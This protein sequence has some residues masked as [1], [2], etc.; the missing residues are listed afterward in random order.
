M[1]CRLS[2]AVFLAVTLATG[3]G[4]ALTL[5]QNPFAAPLV[6]RSLSEARVALERAM[7]RQVTPDWLVPRLDA[8]LAEDDRDRVAMLSALASQHGVPLPPATWAAIDAALA[9]AS[10]GER[11]A[12]CAACMVDITSCQGAGHIAACAL[13]FEMTVAG[14]VN[15][16][17]RQAQAAIAGDDVDRIETGLALV[18]V[19]ATLVAVVSGGSSYVVKAGATMLRLARRMGAITPAFGRV[20]ADAA[21][22][23]VDWAALARA[24]PLA[25]ITDTAKL[26]RLGRIAEDFGTIRANTSTA[27]ALLLARH[28][29]SAEDA[30]RFARLSEVAGTGTRTAV[31]VLGPARAMRTL[32]RV[33]DLTL[34]AIGLVAAFVAQLAMLAMSAVGRRLFRPVA[35]APKA[36]H[37]RRP[38]GREV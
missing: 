15:A 30:A 7:A 13:P 35:P 19:G 34:A 16:L 38:R 32:S 27:D 3:A 31:E 18:G 20:L 1:L 22:V 17:R 12:D 6:D 36:R 26:A 37:D 4:T 33:A 2:R 8:A 28:V 5:S 21:D 23:P 25:E 11:A 10:F 24:A 9:P 14:D 29:H